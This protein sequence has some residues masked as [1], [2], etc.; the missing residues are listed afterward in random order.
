LKPHFVN[1]DWSMPLSIHAFVVESN[2]ARIVVDTC[3]GNDKPRG[4][5][6]WSMRKSTFLDDL[7]QRGA[8][9]ESIDFVL[10]THLHVDH[11]GFNTTLV[12]GK[13]TPTFPN[14]RYLIGRDEW[15]FWKDETDK[16]GPEAK[17][18]SVVPV[19]EAGL[20]DLVDSN[21]TITP[22]VRLIPTPGHTPG[23]VSVLIESQGARA[24]ITG[25]L[26]HHPCQF[27]RPTWVD[28]ADVDTANAARTRDAFMKRFSDGTLV[29]GTHF[30]SPTSGKIVRDGSAYRFEV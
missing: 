7:A 9:R 17:S 30:A 24:V 25:D 29:L 3:I 26:F 27:A 6:Q 2:G 5:P 13:W 19:I 28:S 21:H 1:D 22:E 10:C 23:H 18:D 20:V 4:V 14:A 15:S 11:V 12:N 8:P 16:F